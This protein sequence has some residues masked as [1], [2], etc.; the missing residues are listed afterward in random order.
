MKASEAKEGL[1][2]F[3]H[4]DIG[5]LHKNVGNEHV[6]EWY[7]KWNNGDE[8]AVLSLNY[9]HVHPEQPENQ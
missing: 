8:C 2:V 3:D 7:V 4:E 1:R 9:L 6:S 5:T